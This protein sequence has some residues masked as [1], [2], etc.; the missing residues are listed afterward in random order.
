M[1]AAI[2]LEAVLSEA[3]AAIKELP[4]GVEQGTEVYAQVVW[5][6]TQLGNVEASLQALLADIEAGC[7]FTE[8]GYFGNEFEEM[9]EDMTVQ[10]SHLKSLIRTMKSIG[11][12]A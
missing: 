6:A 11:L 7:S 2:Q 12:G 4:T 1:D 10:I 9:L 3:Q 8:M 5:L